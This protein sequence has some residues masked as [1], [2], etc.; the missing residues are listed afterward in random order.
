[1]SSETQ[2]DSTD[3]S[4]DELP[5]S[6]AFLVER[7]KT[8]RAKQRN[9]TISVCVLWPMLAAILIAVVCVFQDTGMIIGYATA[10]LVFGLVV[11]FGLL[12]VYDQ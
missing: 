12:F 2:A 4:A 6:Q 5:N 11:S 1:M 8:E 3:D 10:L 9:F 7:E